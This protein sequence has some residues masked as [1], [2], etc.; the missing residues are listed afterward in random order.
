MRTLGSAATL[1]TVMFGFGLLSVFLRPA[2]AVAGAV[3]DSNQQTV[4]IV[5]GRSLLEHRLPDVLQIEHGRFVSALD[6]QRACAT[7]NLT[8]DSTLLFFPNSKTCERVTDQTLVSLRLRL[9]KLT[10][11]WLAVDPLDRAQ[12]EAF[13]SIEPMRHSPNQLAGMCGCSADKPP[14]GISTC[15][16]QTRTAGDSIG[17]VEFLA[18]DSDSPTLTGAFSFQ[19][20]SDPA[21]VGLPPEIM[22]SCT[23]GTGTLQCTLTGTAP[24]PAGILQ[25]TFDVSDGTFTLPLETRLEVLAVGDRVFADNFEMDGCP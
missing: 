6:V 11:R 2:D 21:E 10:G 9:Q 7:P 25:L 13:V 16:D 19:R 1:R 24:A 12:T 22:S 20:D 18:T 5:L 14:D 23:S 8:A 17:P 4:V 15:S 3:A